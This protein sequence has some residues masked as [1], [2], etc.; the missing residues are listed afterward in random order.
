MLSILIPVYGY[1]VT[2]LVKNLHKQCLAAGIAY[3][4]LIADD[5]TPDLS[6]VQTNQALQAL[7]YT[8]FFSTQE[9][10]GNMRNREF[11]CEKAAYDW[12]LYLDADT[13]PVSNDFILKYKAFILA[14]QLDAVC[15]GVAYQ[16]PDQISHKT[17][18]RRIYGAQKETFKNIDKVGVGEWKGSNYLIRKSVFSE[19]EIPNLPEKY[20]YVDVVYGITLHEQGHQVA[21]V[22]NPVYHLGLE[23]SEKFLDKTDIAIQNALFIYHHYPKYRKHIKLLRWYELTSNKFVS[24]EIGRFF[25]FT[26][27][28]MRK[29]LTGK[30]PKTWVYQ[31]YK[32]GKLHHLQQLKGIM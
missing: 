17:N 30:N 8:T 26:R 27:Q 12:L 4:I 20:G 2:D 21:F 10:R 1:D 24:R 23:T 5:A 16:S 13:I 25:H 29:H 22:E 6:L 31:L 15:G 3:E 9:N 19:L 28:F 18:L 32:L 7:D 11:L 14:N